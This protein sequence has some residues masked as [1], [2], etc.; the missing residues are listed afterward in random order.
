M[1]FVGPGRRIT[2]DRFWIRPGGGNKME[3]HAIISLVVMLVY[4]FVFI[5]YRA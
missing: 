1:R 5:K 3:F 2:Q 4:I